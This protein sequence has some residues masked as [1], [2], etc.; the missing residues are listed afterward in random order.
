MELFGYTLR[1]KKKLIFGLVGIVLNSDGILAVLVTVTC[2]S[3][4]DWVLLKNKAPFLL[5]ILFEM[6]QF[7][8]KSI[9][10]VIN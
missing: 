3:E 6:E 1:R 2:E 7:E 5:S 9:R 10:W 4:D 8:K